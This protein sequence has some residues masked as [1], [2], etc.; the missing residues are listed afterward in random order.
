MLVKCINNTCVSLTL[1]KYYS[2]V[3]ID[4][5]FEDFIYVI[6]DHGVVDGFMGCRFDLVS[7]YRD[8][9]IDDILR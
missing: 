1:D 6:N 8:N 5:S 9:L 2:I 7:A 4:N 3:D